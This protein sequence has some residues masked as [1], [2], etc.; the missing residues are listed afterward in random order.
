MKTLHIIFLMLIG[1]ASFA[2][3]T[4]PKGAKATAEAPVVNIRRDD[5]VA[6]IEMDFNPYAW[7]GGHLWDIGTTG[8]D[9]CGY[10]LTWWPTTS[11]PNTAVHSHN[12]M[13][14]T[15]SGSMVTPNNVVQIQPLLNNTPYHLKVEKI[16]GLGKICSPAYQ[17]TFDGGD[18]SR[19]NALRN[20][21][22]YFDDFNLPMGAADERKWNNAQGPQT[23]PRFN[24]FFVNDQLH[25]HTLN[26]TR[27]DGA[28]DKSQ[29]AQRARKPIVIENNQRRRIVFDMDGVFSPRSVWYL[30]LNPVK[31]DLTGHLSFFDIDGDTGLPADVLRLKAAGHQFSV[32]LINSQGVTQK[33]AD[34]DLASFGRYMAPNVRRNFDISL[35]TDG[36]TVKVDDAV[37]INETFTTPGSFKPGVYDLLWTGVGYNTSKD[38]NPYYLIHWDNFGFDGPSVQP[39]KVHNYVTQLIGSDLQKANRGSN[40][41]PVFT[42]NV[43]DNI[44]PTSPGVVHEVW[45]V[46]SYQKNDFSLFTIAP[47]D[48][49]KVNGQSY[50]LP[51]GQNNTSPTNPDLVGY[52]GST[53][54]NRVKLADLQV[55]A[56]S[57]IV[58]G[59]NSVQFFAENTGIMNLHLEVLIPDTAP[60]PAYTSPSQIHP[61]LTH[62]ELPALGPSAKITLIDNQEF[63]YEENDLLQGPSTTGVV[64]VEVL[65]GNTHWAGW[66]PSLMHMP[67][68]SAEHWSMGSTKGFKKVNL[69]LRPKGTGN[70]PGTVVASLN[71]MHDAPAPQLRYK[72]DLDTRTFENGNYEL[73][74]QA[75]APS[76]LKSHP[77]YAGAGHKFDAEEWSGAYWPIQISIN[78]PAGTNY[79]FKGTA[80]NLWNIGNSW[81]GGSAPPAGYNGV[82]VIDANCELPSGQSINLPQGAK[83]QINAH[84]TLKMN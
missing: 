28:G 23:D 50:P 84:K 4:S 18:P 58:Q 69:Y 19:V 45:L 14:V 25:V 38:D 26:G 27:N 62:H 29:T 78:N 6:T 68:V 12:S 5:H 46:F 47:G 65:I 2:Q 79:F 57:P 67:A 22:T 39:Y 74:V 10:L 37:V 60:E 3:K 41:E 61:M 32:S 59:N 8:T 24:L 44:M 16:N 21:L 42:I 76:G 63:S 7:H 71:T 49:F 66:A 82:I 53:I 72:F 64:P 48:Y 75:E 20:S 80:G 9:P 70:D 81:L 13:V 40:E 36:I 15:S 1:G 30:D 43:P 56:S 83:L 73:F 31:T 51:P 35:G 34:V 11:Q 55:G 17:T 54:S 52:D 77:A 33:I